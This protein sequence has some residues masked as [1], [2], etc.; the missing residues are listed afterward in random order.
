MSWRG[1]ADQATATYA[2]SALVVQVRDRL[3]WGRPVTHAIDSARP[4]RRGSAH[5]VQGGVRA[6]Q[7]A[8]GRVEKSTAID[9]LGAMGS[10]SQGN[11]LTRYRVHERLIAT[12]IPA[13]A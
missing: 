8:A 5:E 1:G 6:E 4:K 3:R 13:L 10:P 2:P 9:L 7:L 11:S 12:R